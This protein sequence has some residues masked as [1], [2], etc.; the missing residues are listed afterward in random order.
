M[1][2][3]HPMQQCLSPETLYT[4]FWLATDDPAAAVL[5]RCVQYSPSLDPSPTPHPPFLD[6]LILSWVH[7]ALDSLF[8]VGLDDDEWP[9]T[10]DNACRV[11]VREWC[12]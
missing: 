12:G 3:C 6:A 9:W 2:R 5:F 10:M 11:E 8:F 7:Y 1:T 4:T